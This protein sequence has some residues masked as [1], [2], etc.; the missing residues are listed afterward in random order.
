MILPTKPLIV[1]I[2]SSKT[3]TNRFFPILS[4]LHLSKYSTL[5]TT[6]YRH[7]DRC[8]SRYELKKFPPLKNNDLSNVLHAK[9]PLWEYM[10]FRNQIRGFSSNA[11][12]TGSTDFDTYRERDSAL[13][14]SI[15]GPPNAGMTTLI[16]RLDS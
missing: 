16:L 5:A 6:R 9:L 12:V 8:W 4:S 14:V 10:Y 2:S 3:A 15:L 13:V 11:E 1:S 7:C